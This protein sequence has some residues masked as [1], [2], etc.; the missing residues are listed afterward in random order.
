MSYEIID[1]YQQASIMLVT[2]AMLC[3]M[4]GTKHVI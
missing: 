4:N 3:T 1:K 2:Y